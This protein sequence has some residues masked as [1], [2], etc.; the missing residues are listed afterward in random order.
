MIQLVNVKNLFPQ[1]N[2]N[3]KSVFIVGVE[4]YPNS[5]DFEDGFIGNMARTIEFGIFKPTITRSNRFISRPM[6]QLRGVLGKELIH[7]PCLNKFKNNIAENDKECNSFNYVTDY[8][9]CFDVKQYNIDAFGCVHLRVC[10]VC[11]WAGGNNNDCDSCKD[12]NEMHL[13]TEWICN[14]QENC[15]IQYKVR[16]PYQGELSHYMNAKSMGFMGMND[17]L[18]KIEE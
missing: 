5:D 2:V 16:G 1:C 14:H 7:T 17:N 12:N 11:G 8:L 15:A 6:S 4:Y 10:V 18:I 3:D 13:K 9:G